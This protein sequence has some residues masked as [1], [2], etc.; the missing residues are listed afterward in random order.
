MSDLSAS[1]LAVP[2]RFYTLG[3]VA[4]LLSASRTTIYRWRLLGLQVV[5][6]A[7]VVRISESS[8]QQ[9]IALHSTRGK[10]TGHAREPASLL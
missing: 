2:E 9:F 3:E 7:G 4:K 8:L 6:I 1:S 5:R 10:H